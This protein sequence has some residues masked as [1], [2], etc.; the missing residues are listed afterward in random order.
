MKNTADFE[1]ALERLKVAVSKAR[2]KSPYTR[3]QLEILALLDQHKTLTTSEASKI[4]SLTPGAVTQTIETLVKKNL[5]LRELNPDDR[6][7]TDLSLSGE[8]QALARSFHEKR[9][10]KIRA[11]LNELT[12]EEAELL[13]TLTNKLAA[14]IDKHTEK[15]E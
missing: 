9:R 1:Q 14:L 6:R 12:D 13:L 8:G 3:T 4:L 5:V 15:K 10:A 11:L 7:I 2:E